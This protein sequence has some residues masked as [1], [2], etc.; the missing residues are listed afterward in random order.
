MHSREPGADFVWSIIAPR[1]APGRVTQARLIFSRGDI[2]TF[3]FRFGGE[4]PDTAVL[5]SNRQSPRQ[6]VSCMHI[7]FFFGIH[8]AQLLVINCIEYVNCTS[9]INYKFV[10]PI[11][12][13]AREFALLPVCRDSSQIATNNYFYFYFSSARKP[14]SLYPPESIISSVETY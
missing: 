8:N 9:V 5:S 10:I 1:C 3:E 4:N 14:N 2:K 6:F 7:F 11:I 13:N 12:Q